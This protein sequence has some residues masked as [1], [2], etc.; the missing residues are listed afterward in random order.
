MNAFEEIDKDEEL[1]RETDALKGEIEVSKK[2]Q[3]QLKDFFE[4]QKERIKQEKEARLR[5]QIEES[6][7]FLKKLEEQKTTEDGGEKEDI[8]KGIETLR[9]NIEM[10]KGLLEKK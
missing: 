8:G 6:E 3:E 7:D 5:Q 2:T 10:M 4:E 1:K 9:K